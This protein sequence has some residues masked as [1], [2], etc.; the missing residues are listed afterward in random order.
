MR[1]VAAALCCLFATP[2][3]AAEEAQ[4]LCGGATCELIFRL[5]DNYEIRFE[6][7]R[8]STAAVSEGIL[9]IPAD[10]KINGTPPRF[11]IPDPAVDQAALQGMARTARELLEGGLTTA[12]A[13]P[14]RAARRGGNAPQVDPH[15]DL[16]FVP[17][18]AA[19]SE[20]LL[21]G[22]CV[23]AKSALMDV[24]MGNLLMRAG[25]NNPFMG[26]GAEVTALER[27]CGDHTQTVMDKLR[28][29]IDV[30]QNLHR[31]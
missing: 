19:L 18:T 14:P 29:Q 22:D 17:A 6:E 21:P 7:K 8:P 4:Q 28:E 15:Y 30:M 10:G 26:A 16:P 1:L 23:A 27:A 11:E 25:Q 12:P 20:S 13:T 3:Q 31:G 2:V 5:V 24:A 9:L